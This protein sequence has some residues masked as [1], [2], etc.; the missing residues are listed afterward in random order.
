M[1]KL[2]QSE[3]SIFDRHSHRDTN[4]PIIRLRTSK[5]R[6]RLAL[7]RRARGE[8]VA[9]SLW[10][11][12]HGTQPRAFLICEHHHRNHRNIEWSSLRTLTFSDGAQVE[13][14]PAPP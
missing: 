5:I 13:S 14:S 10:L 11:K 2:T 6:K 4:D 1:L 12:T 9:Q 3:A 7:Y 8:N